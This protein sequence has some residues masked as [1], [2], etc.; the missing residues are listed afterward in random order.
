MRGDDTKLNCMDCD[1]GLFP[2]ESE[3]L[4][5]NGQLIEIVGLDEIMEQVRKLKMPQR[6]LVADEL[7]ARAKERRAVPEGSEKLYRD[8]LMDEYDRRYLTVM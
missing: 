6:K 5:V 7:L 2:S 1:T 3:K 4:L 8:A